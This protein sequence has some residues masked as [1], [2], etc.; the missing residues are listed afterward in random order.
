MK[1][2]ISIFLVLMMVVTLL[3]M[4]VFA[5]D[6]DIASGVFSK[7]EAISW[8]IS[9]DY[10]LT[11]SGEGEMPYECPWADY[12]AKITSVVIEEGIT[13]VRDMEGMS[14]MKSVKLPNSLEAVAYYAFSECT[15]LKSL[16]IP[17]GVTEI[18][19]V[20]SPVVQHLKVLFCRRA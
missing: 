14:G 11:I 7:D 12:R 3:P 1:R 9:S 18:A 13:C 6:A 4:A 16:V 2:I 8:K 17:E 15:S 19:S 10:T 20:H 5:D